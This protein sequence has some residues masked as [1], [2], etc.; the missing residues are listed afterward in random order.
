MLAG[1]VPGVAV[2]SYD[3]IYRGRLGAPVPFL[4]LL[5]VILPAVLAAVSGLLI[6]GTILNQA[7][8]QNAW[9]AA[10][11]GLCVSLVAWLAYVPVLSILAGR[12]WNMG[13]AYKVFLVLLFGS[14]L[15]GWLIAAVGI[16]T[17]LLLYR[18]RKFLP[19]M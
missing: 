12:D 7:K 5:Y 15:V 17:A 6:G 19:A 11:R 1:V 9:Q 18:M 10:V 3:L 4:L 13:F 2:I 14:I 8:T 16:V